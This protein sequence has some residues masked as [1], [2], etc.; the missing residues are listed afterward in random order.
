MGIDR[1]RESVDTLISIP[2][3][4]LLQIATPELSM[5]DAFRMADEVLVNAVKVLAI[6]SISLNS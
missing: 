3:Q 6:L 5:V 2:N 4:R 1:L